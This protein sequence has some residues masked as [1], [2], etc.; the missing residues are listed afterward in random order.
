LLKI[1]QDLERL[2][3]SYRDLYHYAPV[4]YFSLDLEG[5]MVAVNDTMLQALGFRRR[6]LL[7]QP[8]ARLL[9]QGEAAHP[10]LLRAGEVECRWV[11]RDGMVI[12]VSIRSVPVFDE[13]GKLVRTRSAAQ[14]VTESNRLAQELRR[15][16]KDLEKANQDLQAINKELDHF[17]WTVAHELKEPLRS[18]AATSRQVLQAYEHNTLSECSGD[19]QS[20]VQNSL[21]LAR[22]VNNLLALSRE[23]QIVQ[24]MTSFSLGDALATVSSDLA[25]L[26]RRQKARVNL[27]GPAP[28]IRGDVDRVTQLLANLV[29]N[30]LKYNT[31]AEPS[32]EIGTVDS[33]DDGLVTLYVRDNGIGIDPQFHERIFE[34]FE[35]LHPHDQYEGTGVGLA[36]CKQI[37]EAHGGKIWVDSQPGQGATFY[38]TLPRGDAI[39]LEPTRNAAVPSLS[40]TEANH[41]AEPC[42]LLLVEDMD[43][44]GKVAQRLLGKTGHRVDWCQSAEQAWDYLQHNR[45]DLVLLDINLPAMNGLE[46]CRRL[47]NTPGQSDLLVALFSQADQESDLQIGLE[48]G[49]DHVLS[50]ELLCQP[51]TLTHQL[52]DIL[53]R[54]VVES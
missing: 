10:E 33:S 35:R 54:R 14:D 51:E 31:T 36:I 4:M 46:L 16:T 23:G 26:I 48:A 18:L 25:D 42:R 2:K 41:S 40:A 13:Q 52:R 50:K 45:P 21:R 44:L 6:D 30:G 7:N 43:E 5:R 8:Y 9:P 29:G 34:K 22:L 47:R 3:E 49:A 12:D 24:T 39:P 11:Q 20:L 27:V 28:M 1:N 19:L 32:V 17:N 15:R 53:A 37:V 38:F